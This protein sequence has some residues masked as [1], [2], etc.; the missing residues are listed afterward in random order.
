MEQNGESEPLLGKS[1]HEG[2]MK[3]GVESDR[4]N[5]NNGIEANKMNCNLEG[6]SRSKCTKP[7]RRRWFVTPFIYGEIINANEGE[8]VENPIFSGN[9]SAFAVLLLNTSYSILLCMHANGNPKFLFH[10][11]L[12][13]SCIMAIG[14]VFIILFNAFRKGIE[15]GQVTKS[16]SNVKLKSKLENILQN[17]VSLIPIVLFFVI[18]MLIDVLN[19]F[20]SFFAT[21]DDHCDYN[22][23]YSHICFHMLRIIF[24]G[25][26]TTFCV[27]FHS[28]EFT[29]TCIVSYGLMFIGAANLSMWL[30]SVMAEVNERDGGTKSKRGQQMCDTDSTVG[31]YLYPITVEYSLLACECLF[32]F[33][34][35]RKATDRSKHS[36]K[37][38]VESDF[39]LSS[40]GGHNLKD[41]GPIGILSSSENG[42]QQSSGSVDAGV[43]SVYKEGTGGNNAV[44]EEGTENKKTLADYTSLAISIILFPAI[45]LVVCVSGFF[46]SHLSNYKHSDAQKFRFFYIWSILLYLSTT[47]TIFAAFY[48]SR[49]FSQIKK[50]ITGL[51]LMVMVCAVGNFLDSLLEIFATTELINCNYWGS[52]SNHRNLSYADNYSCSRNYSCSFS[53]ETIRLD[54]EPGLYLATE[55]TNI[56]QIFLLITFLVYC[57]R[58]VKPE[59][60]NLH[61][62]R[63]CFDTIL[64][65]L[66]FCSFG[67]WLNDSLFMVTVV[68]PTDVYYGTTRWRNLFNI[69]TPFTLFFRFNGMLLFIQVFTKNGNSNTHH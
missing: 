19:V 41:T 58:V 9:I 68:S 51:E 1:T 6:N 23:Y 47:V 42:S 65:F 28:L 46:I 5:S 38:N 60:P 26:V 15:A 61:F 4:I 25:F 10:S 37:D 11:N 8:I 3:V 43:I 35:H 49:E 20:T 39:V 24:M 34:V 21:G 44:E 69:I 50:A 29:N 22:V 13:N 56:I 48:F 66:A 55:I 14:T 59:D 7:S 12:Y 32:A 18:G 62:E 45:I 40:N 33:I 30:D 17:H 36:S 53:E 54:V 27:N 31:P 63:K 64:L 52:S 57:Q 2:G 67:F 16:N